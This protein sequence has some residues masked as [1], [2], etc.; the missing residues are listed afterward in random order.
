MLN[1]RSLRIAIDMTPLLPNGDNGGAKVLVL[2]LLQ[3]LQSL[4]P[5]HNFLL[6]TAPWNHEQLGQYETNNTKCLLME[7][8]GKGNSADNLSILE[9]A[10]NKVIY[11]LQSKVSKV[12]RKKTLL[13]QQKVDVLFCPFSAPTYAEKGVPLV[14]IAYD[15][16][17]LEYPFF[18]DEQERQ[19][20]TNFLIN[21]INKSQKIIC[22][23][24]FTKRSFIYHFNTPESQL[25][26]VHISIHDR[27]PKL[28]EDSLK[29]RLTRLGLSNREYAFYPANYWKHKNH[30]LLLT[31]YG[32]YRKQF[33]GEAVDLVFTGALQ[34]E[35]Q[36]L[37]TAIAL[38]G[39]NNHV[40]F[41]GFL[42]EKN[43]AAVWHGCQC[44]IFPSLYE[45]FGIPVLEA[46]RF[47]KPVVCSNV[48]SL[49]EIGGDAVLS[50]D[51]RRPDEIVS[52]LAKVTGDRSY[53]EQLVNRGYQRL[54]LFDGKEMANQYLE[55]L[56][57]VAS[58]KS[59]SIQTSTIGIYEDGWS[60]PEFEILI[61]EGS[62]GREL[63]LF[64]EVPEFYPTPVA[65]VKVITKGKR[66][67]YQCS[68]GESQKIVWSISDQGEAI[69]VKVT[70]SFTPSKL[71]K[72][73]DN[74]QLGVRVRDCT[75]K[76]PDD[77]CTSIFSL[78]SA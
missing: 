16:Q 67:V 50:F 37:R 56:E 47:G 57:T 32:M 68:R 15:L 59:T 63:S 19:H 45:G 1:K 9:R 41:L 51:P 44:L 65:R 35:E 8:L 62:A 28:D 34:S 52:C 5:K 64:F 74:R 61:E 12:L 60:A 76:S 22:I 78:I 3:R 42:D 71:L 75:V 6:L 49:P 17:H 13:Q 30:R 46:M 33:P 77:G 29:Q 54:K 7:H 14:A 21:L 11:K 25:G 26:V 31:A 23:S 55:I 18:F 70:P 73:A 27:L 39:L 10:F 58:N 20:R 36:E 43:L 40:H 69:A 53:S 72:N 66:T 4:A 2:D 38:M 48:G 24:D